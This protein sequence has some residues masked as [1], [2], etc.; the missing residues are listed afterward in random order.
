MPAI[1][2]PL[3]YALIDA[4]YGLP[5]SSASERPRLTERPVHTPQM[6]TKSMAQ[7]SVMETQAVFTRLLSWRS[8]KA[9]RPR[10]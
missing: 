5:F 8:V 9:L 3:G 7:T 2:R 4:S 10:R 6:A 1:I